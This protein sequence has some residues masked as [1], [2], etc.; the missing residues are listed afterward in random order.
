MSLTGVLFSPNGRIGPRDF[1][2]G[3]IV[4]VAITMVMT[5]GAV[6]AAPAL[7]LLMLFMPYLYLCVF[8]KRLH[9]AGQSAWWYLA[10]LVAYWIINMISQSILTPILAPGANELVEEAAYLLQSGDLQAFIEISQQANRAT[11][12]VNLLS[13]FLVNALLG[14]FIARLRSDPN[15]NEHGPPPAEVAGDTFS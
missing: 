9:D 6:Y 3:V 14:F 1:W 8:G 5:I 15:S 2:R 10:L 7:G 11:L 4:L 13:L 12:F